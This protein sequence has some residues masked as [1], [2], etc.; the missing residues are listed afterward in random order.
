M[1]V[2]FSLALALKEKGFDEPCY[3]GYDITK[4]NKLRSPHYGK[5]SRQPKIKYGKYNRYLK[6]LIKAPTYDQVIDWLREKH[7]IKVFESEFYNRSGVD[8]WYVKPAQTKTKYPSLQMAL[9]AALLLI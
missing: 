9:Q 2:H 6:H 3:K 1:E 8:E 4:G 7:K 5:Y